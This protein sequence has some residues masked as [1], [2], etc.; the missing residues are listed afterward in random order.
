MRSNCI[1][2]GREFEARSCIQITCSEECRGERIRRRHKEL[3]RRKR[4]EKMDRES[5]LEEKL[6]EC[7]RLGISYGEYVGRE[8]IAMIGGVRV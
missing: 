2:C 8:T 7:K 5:T 3:Q 4:K 1:I 6:K